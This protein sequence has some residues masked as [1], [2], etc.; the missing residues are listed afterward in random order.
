MINPPQGRHLIDTNGA[1]HVK[2]SQAAQI[3]FLALH[4]RTSPLCNSFSARDLNPPDDRKDPLNWSRERKLL[5][6]LC[7]VMYTI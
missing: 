2:H 7:V 4:L 1:L 3:V 5:Q 6:R